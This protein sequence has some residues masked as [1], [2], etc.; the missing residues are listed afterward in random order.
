MYSKVV[1]LL[2]PE[3][4][5]KSAGIYLESLTNGKGRYPL[6]RG[7]TSSNTDCLSPVSSVITPANNNIYLIRIILW[8]KIS[9]C[10]INEFIIVHAYP[11]LSIFT[12]TIKLSVFPLL[13]AKSKSSLS[14]LWLKLDQL[15]DIYWL[16]MLI[17]LPKALYL[18]LKW[19]L[20]KTNWYILIK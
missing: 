3:A 16:L 18:F 11:T 13:V 6:I 9:Y 15:W 7:I 8:C 10:D 1:Y 4:N 2:L 12:Q 20:N 17:C 19:C 14:T 5:F